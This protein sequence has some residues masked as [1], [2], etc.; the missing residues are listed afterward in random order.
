MDNLLKQDWVGP[1]EK[2]H[3]I[4]VVFAI[5]SGQ[6]EVLNLDP[7]RFYTG[8]YKEM[9]SI[10]A[11]KTHQN[12]NP[13]LHTLNSALIKRH[14]KITNKRTLGFI[15]R[16]TT[17]SLQLLHNSSLSCLGMVKIIFQ[18]NKAVDVLL[19]VDSSTGDGK[20]QPEIEDPEYANASTTALYELVLLNRHYHPVV[21]RYA[22]HI[23]NGV[24]G[25]G[26][27]SLPPQFGKWLVLSIYVELYF[28]IFD[29]IMNK[30]M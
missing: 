27:G 9:L 15:K 16:L 22:R 13:L 26:E 17:L 10:H 12:F 30:E 14:K 7:T 29:W 18:M 8:L 4:Q 3:C 23:A 28:K 25:T 5:L 20:F 2:L 24:P 1:R 19:D 6:G 21:G 11:S